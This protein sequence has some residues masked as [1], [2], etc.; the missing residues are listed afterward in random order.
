[1]GRNEVLTLRFDDKR[2]TVSIR[3]NAINRAPYSRGW[4]E[5]LRSAMDEVA[6]RDL[7][8]DLQDVQSLGSSGLG[9]LIAIHQEVSTRGGQV[10]LDNVN[11][12]VRD[13]LR[14]TRLERLFGSPV[15]DTEWD[16][17]DRKA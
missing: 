8:V 5:V 16:R 10:R 14:L 9:V 2:N 6:Q 13:T 15:E 11:D 12:C 1:M 17:V 7:W 3:G 4:S